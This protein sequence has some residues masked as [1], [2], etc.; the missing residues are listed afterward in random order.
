MGFIYRVN[1][2]R[3]PA[4]QG[5]FQSFMLADSTKLEYH[6]V[7]VIFDLQILSELLK[8]ILFKLLEYTGDE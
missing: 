6:F 7:I 1:T 5:T 2:A 4:K 3:P 8:T